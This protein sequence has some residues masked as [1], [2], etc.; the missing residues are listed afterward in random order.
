MN[1]RIVISETMAGL[2]FTVKLKTMKS[3]EQ[4]KAEAAKNGM[5]IKFLSD[6]TKEKTVSAS[7]TLLI[8]YTS[9]ESDTMKKAVSILEKIL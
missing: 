5:K 9:L 2:H 4:L 6:Y 3:D 7:S 1:D 8:N